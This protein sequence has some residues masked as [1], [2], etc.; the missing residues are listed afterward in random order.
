MKLHVLF[1]RSGT[2]LAA[3]PLDDE[4][5]RV[6]KPRPVPQRGQFTADITVPAQYGDMSFF[7][8][9]TRM[10]VKRREDGAELVVASGATAATRT[11]SQRRS[12][13]PASRAR[14]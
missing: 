7:D 4:D 10:K 9:C 6:P 2:I 14:R 8:V 3:V 1:D 12:A 5:P 11:R 13:R